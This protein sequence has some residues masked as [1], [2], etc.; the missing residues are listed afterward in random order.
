MKWTSA[1]MV[2]KKML[3]STVIHSVYLLVWSNDIIH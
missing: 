2:I 3:I 1:W